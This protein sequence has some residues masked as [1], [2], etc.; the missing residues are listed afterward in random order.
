[1]LPSGGGTENDMKKLVSFILIL[2]MLVPMLSVG[3]FAADAPS[4]EM[5]SVFDLSAAGVDPGDNAG[6]GNHQ[7]RTVHTSHGEYSAYITGTYTDGNGHTVNKW[8]LIKTDTEKGTSEVVFTG[9]KYY[10][11]S[12][13]SLLVDKDENVWAIT[14]TSDSRRNLSSEGIDGRAHRLDAK[15]G[16]VTSYTDIMSGGAQDGYGYA[17]CFYDRYKDRI[18]VVHAGGDYVKGST[19][20]ASFNWTIFDM[21]TNTWQSRVRLAR[22]DARHCYMY[23]Y[24]DENGGLML[25]AQ[26]DI[27]AA[28][29]GYPE[30]G[31][32]TGLYYE[33]RQ[34][35]AQHGITRWAANYCWDQL[36]LYYFPKITESKYVKYSVCEA[37]YSRVVGTQAERNSLAGRLSNYYPAIQNNNGGD[38]L[39]TE[40]DSGQKLLHITY[41]KAYIQAAMD[42]SVSSDCKW[43]HQVW[44]VT[45]GSNAVRLYDG[46]IV[47]EMIHKGG[48]SFRLYEDS[49][50]NVNLI[51][52]NDGTLSVYRVEYNGLGG[53]SYHKIGSTVGLSRAGSL[54]NISS[55]RGGSITDDKLN[56][57]YMGAG[58][59]MLTQLTLSPAECEPIPC[60][61]S[62]Y[63]SAEGSVAPTCTADG[64]DCYICS[65]C[66]GKSYE[67]VAA[68]GHSFEETYTAPTCTEEGSVFYECKDCSYSE[69]VAVSATGHSFASGYCI[70]CREPDPDFKP[71]YSHGDINGDGKLTATDSN[72]IK[73]IIAG[74]FDTVKEQFDACDLNGD[75]TV[76]AKDSFLLTKRLLGNG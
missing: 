56:V 35:M 11:S 13:V 55:A 19:T 75:G 5:S 7:T 43:Y 18:V 64:V 71:V 39:L 33:D 29:L 73:R 4:F 50:G 53:Y 6:H 26:R 14:S 69:T 8:S 63:L 59:Y 10:D 44:D 52:G 2:A 40:T 41:N 76:N 1:M 65:Y 9:E 16:E 17:T 72:L 36:D 60:S 51:S 67:S 61:H 25:I 66:N 38:F 42:R 46:V 15:T 30:V 3:A 57:L 31:N 58:K 24:I 20:G 62:Y 37:D 49:L 21:K 28:S 34:Y 68:K 12:Q 32:D 54:I 70:V 48:F 45:D 47:D 74:K 22:I 27:K 23:G